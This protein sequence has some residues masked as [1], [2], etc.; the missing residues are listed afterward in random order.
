MNRR[1]VVSTRNRRQS[2][3]GPTHIH[4]AVKIRCYLSNSDSQALGLSGSIVQHT[5]REGN[6]SCM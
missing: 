2:S 1:E 3:G 5:E 4:C 6:A